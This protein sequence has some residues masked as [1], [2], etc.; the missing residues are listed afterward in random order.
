MPN[1][2][3]FL[4]EALVRRLLPGIKCEGMSALYEEPV[5]KEEKSFSFTEEQFSQLDRA[6]R[7]IVSVVAKTVNSPMPAFSLMD[8]AEEGEA[9]QAEPLQA[10]AEANTED[11]LSKWRERFKGKVGS[12]KSQFSPEE[13]E[14]ALELRDKYYGPE[15]EIAATAKAKKIKPTKGIGQMSPEE[16]EQAGYV[17]KVPKEVLDDFDVMVGELKEIGTIYQQ[18]RSWYHNIK[19]M[20]LDVAQEDKGAA[21]YGLLIA[22]FSPRAKFSINLAEATFMFKAITADAASNPEKL[23]KY[24]EAFSTAEKPEGGQAEGKSPRHIGHLKVADFALN[25]IKPD[26]AGKPNEVTGELEYNEEYRWNSTIDI[27]MVTAF[28]PMLK[29]ASTA[30]EWAVATGK[31]MSDPMSYVYLSELVAKKAKQFG[32]LPHE[33]QAIIWVAMKKRQ[34][35]EDAATTDDSFRQIEEAI[36]NVQSIHRDLA[37]INEELKKSSWAKVISN[38]IDERGIETASEIVLGRNEIDPETGKPVKV[39]GVR[40][41]AMSGKKGDTFKYFPDDEKAPGPKADRRIS[42]EPKTAKADRAKEKKTLPYED[43]QFSDLKTFW[44]LNNVVMMPTGKLTNL[45]NSII[46]YLSEGFSTDSAAQTIISDFNRAS[47]TSAGF[48]DEVLTFDSSAL[49]GR[50]K[51]FLIG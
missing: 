32:L 5:T 16:F 11:E 18:A 50:I 6:A 22:T 14:D 20:L 23:L 33:L 44:V 27:W 26:L 31:L 40:S 8:I 49:Y 34:S 39:R 28:Y 36:Q 17:I 1:D 24:A 47:K 13:T 19:A 12:G 4:N 37:E 3:K 30:G 10:V 35:G 42:R 46:M 29:K 43:E 21:L 25:L 9:S 2:K 48:L 38:D 51:R 7:E 41:I 45:S 15:G